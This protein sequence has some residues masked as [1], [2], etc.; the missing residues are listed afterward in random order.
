[1][2]AAA[3]VLILLKERPTATRSTVSLGTISES[4]ALLS[5]GR[6]YGRWLWPVEAPDLVSLRSVSIASDTQM[7]L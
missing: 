4:W 5:V 3:A 6:I 2:A 7:F 1:M